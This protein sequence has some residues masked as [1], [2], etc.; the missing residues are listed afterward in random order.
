MNYYNEFD[1][2]KAAW[3][4]ELIKRNVIAPGVV[5][6]RSIHDV[7]PDD[8]GGFTQ[9]HFFAG[10]GIWS[11]ALRLAG[12][13]DDEP[14]WTGSCPCQPFSVAGEGL[15]LKDERHLF[16][17]WFGLIEARRPLT[18]FGEQVS[19]GSGL[20]WLDVVHASMD[21]AGYTL[22][23]VD[24]CAAGFGAPMRSQRLY[25]VAETDEGGRRRWAS[26]AEGRDGDRSAG[27]RDESDRLAC[28]RGSICDMGKAASEGL[29]VW[30]GK[31]VYG[32][33]T[34]GV[35]ERPSDARELGAS[36]G[37]GSLPEPFRGVHRGEEIR[38]SRHGE[39]ERSGCACELA[40]PPESRRR[41]ERADGRG[42]RSGGRAERRA[43]GLDTGGAP[44]P[45][46]GFW[47]DAEWIWCRDEKWRA[48][49][50]GSFP[51]AH[52]APARVGRL[53]GYGDAINA[54]Q[55]AAFI[56]AYI[57]VKQGTRP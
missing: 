41:E 54:Y 34:R 18:V 22:G 50:P 5:D 29:P 12:W 26:H 33:D 3:L 36:A 24:T 37:A 49:K 32:S 23:V 21:S 2:K 10:V 16:P 31:A 39:S 43:A 55:A 13:P 6:E 35:A 47:R 17:A 20:T 30:S 8:L 11:Y 1:A 19:D 40:T 45:V 42:I 51:L 46:N 27:E 38:G 15:A 52:G 14:A 28:G 53:R 4:R 57:E 48:V 9:C 7:R 25:L 44:G 56:R